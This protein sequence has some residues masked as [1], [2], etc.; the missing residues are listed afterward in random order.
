MRAL[1]NTYRGCSQEWNMSGAPGCFLERWRLEGERKDN[2]E[3][4]RLQRKP[5][6]MWQELFE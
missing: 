6:M 1:G 4:I 3:R 2:S 5:K